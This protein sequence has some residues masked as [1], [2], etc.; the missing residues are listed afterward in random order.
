MILQIL[1]LSCTRIKCLPQPLYKLDQLQKFFVRGCEL[2]LDMPSSSVILRGLKSQVYLLLLENGRTWDAWK[3]HFI[4][5]ITAREKITCQN[6]RIILQNV[7]SNLLQL[8]KLSINVKLSRA[9][10]PY[11]EKWNVRMKDMVEVC[12]LNWLKTLTLFEKE[13]SR[14]DWTVINQNSFSHLVW[15]LF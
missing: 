14:N 2:F 4:G 3:C 8:K 13:V 9:V 11:N 12:S 1:D 7:I 10:N 15:I 6:C 5:I